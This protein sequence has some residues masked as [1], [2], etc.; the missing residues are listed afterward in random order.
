MD[1]KNTSAPAKQDKGISQITESEKRSWGSIAFIWV[2]TMI[3]IPMLMVGGIFASALTIN[4]IFWATVIGF[5]VCCLLMV[6]DG[7]IGSDLGLVLERGR[8][9]YYN[10]TVMQDGQ[11]FTHKTQDLTEQT[12]KHMLQTIYILYMNQM[13]LVSM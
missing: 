9:Y 2:G 6:L 4:S 13:L 1:E 12:L 7:I 5:A 11:L 10:F 3:C 8:T